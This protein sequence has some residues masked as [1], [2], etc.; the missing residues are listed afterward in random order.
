MPFSGGC[1]SRRLQTPS[2]AWLKWVSAP[3]RSCRCCG[4][5]TARLIRV[6]AGATAFL[7][8]LAVAG[9]AIAT[10]WT[11]KRYVTGL[12]SFTNSYAWRSLASGLV[13]AAIAVF[14]IWLSVCLFGSKPIQLRR[15]A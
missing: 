10:L 15:T 1:N 14:L 7:T 6:L 11:Y 8:G 12:G 2:A 13:E 3:V 5:N 9:W 4:M